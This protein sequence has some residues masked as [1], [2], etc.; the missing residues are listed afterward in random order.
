MFNLFKKKLFAI[1][2]GKEQSVA[3]ESKKTAIHA[4][5]STSKKKKKKRKGESSS[6]SDGRPID[7][8]GKK[9]SQSRS[10]LKPVAEKLPPKSLPSVPS[11]ALPPKPERPANLTEIPVV[12][13]KI[14][15]LDLPLHEDVQFGIQHAG[16]KYC[17]PIQEK[18][19]PLLLEGRDLAGKAQ[20]GTGKTAA[21]LLAIFN[22]LLMHPLENRKPGCPR[23][24]VLAPTR[25]LAIQI[26][27]DANLL[28]VFTNLVSVV[29][30]GGM[31]HEKQRRNLEEI[32]DLVVGTPGRV[33]DYLRCGALNLSKVEVL[34]IDETDRM[35]DMGFINDVKRIVSQLPPK[36]QR[37]T[38][39]FSAT[40]DDQLWRHT[41]N[42][43]ASPAVVESEPEK[44]VNENIE[45]RFYSVLRDEKL[46]LLLYLLRTE[47]FERVIIFGN[48]KDVNLRLKQDLE[49]YGYNVPV[50]SGDISQERRI[51]ILERFRAGQEKIVIATD[52]AARGI[53]VDNVS[54]VINYDLPERAEDYVHRIGRTGRAGHSGKSVSFLCEYGAYYLPE[55]EKLLGVEFHSTQ[56]TEEMLKMP[57]PVPGAKPSMR[58]NE[59]NSGAS[60]HRSRRRHR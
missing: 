27:K 30:F 6:L 1:F 31:D 13:G 53:H 41:S 4:T 37:Q 24:L 57:D 17:T 21:F 9:D 42:W 52:V 50:L 2:G 18:T 20:T 43:L 28:G 33:I 55:I 7:S 60:G 5:Q 19:L 47:P 3:I 38:L 15:F 34:V 48:R 44:L 51:K 39:F 45:Q 16:F 46:A 59:R 40:L 26:Q 36:N 8:V 49:R 29:V 58:K 23:A 32:V 54:L 10:K 22:R 25:E 56:P 35:L 12:E 14:R 11:V